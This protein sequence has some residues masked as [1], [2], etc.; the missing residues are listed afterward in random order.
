MKREFGRIESN[1]VLKESFL[2][3][4][5]QRTHSRRPMVD[6]LSASFLQTR[7]SIRKQRS[8]SNFNIFWNNNPK[9]KACEKNERG[10]KCRY[11]L[12]YPSPIM[13]N[14]NPARQLLENL[15]DDFYRIFLK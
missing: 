8:G 7:I 12:P 6:S 1:Q 2:G 14:F 10:S 4:S 3:F 13:G 11:N 5:T 15:P 9:R